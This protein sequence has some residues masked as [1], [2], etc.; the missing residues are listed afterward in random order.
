VWLW[1][2]ESFRL[3]DGPTSATAASQQEGDGDAPPPRPLQ[4][5]VGS[6]ASVRK[7]L[8]VNGVAKPEI[9][10]SRD[11][12]EDGD[13]A[14]TTTTTGKKPNVIVEWAEFHA[15]RRR[16]NS[17][18]GLDT[19]SSV[20]MA[21][22]SRSLDSVEFKPLVERLMGDIDPA[23]RSRVSIPGKIRSR[24]MPLD[25]RSAEETALR[26]IREVQADRL[27]TDELDFLDAVDGGLKMPE[28]QQRRL[29]CIW[30]ASNSPKRV[31][32]LFVSPMTTSRNKKKVFPSRVG[33][34]K[35]LT[36]FNSSDWSH[37]DANGETHWMG[38]ALRAKAG[39][40]QNTRKVDEVDRH[41]QRR[42]ITT[43]RSSMFSWLQV[44]A[45]SIKHSVCFN[46]WMPMRKP[47]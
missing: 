2:G 36:R 34:R 19:S 18:Q 5:G 21:Q 30:H 26:V 33:S 28:Q 23:A 40:S 32:K 45:C 43:I 11:I 47:V 3:D 8:Q 16:R 4:Q 20:S 14:A 25:N 29:S 7:Q 9:G 39:V 1:R 12:G 42:T 13:A 41:H 10:D 31:M 17:E 15:R 6:L 35:R 44:R 38:S 24:S 46:L 27:D 37:A 22:I